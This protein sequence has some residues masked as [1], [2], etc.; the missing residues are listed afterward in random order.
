MEAMPALAPLTCNGRSRDT[1]K[2]SG[3]SG[4]VKASAREFGQHLARRSSMPS[5]TQP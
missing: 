3:T 1:A 5:I 4:W 2:V